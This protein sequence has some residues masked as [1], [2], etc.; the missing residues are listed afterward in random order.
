MAEIP[1]SSKG[2]FKN[3]VFKRSSSG[4]RDTNI[5]KQQKRENYPVQMLPAMRLAVSKL[6]HFKTLNPSVRIFSTIIN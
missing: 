2:S 6:L 1:K 5:R 4:T 3:E